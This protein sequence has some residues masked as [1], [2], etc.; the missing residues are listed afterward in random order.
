MMPTA[1]ENVRVISLPDSGHVLVRR[2][3]GETCLAP[4]LS[5]CLP[6]LGDVCVALTAGA[7]VLV[8]DRVSGF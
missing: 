4:H 6:A 7:D 1:W 3:T 5:S 8:I 2:P